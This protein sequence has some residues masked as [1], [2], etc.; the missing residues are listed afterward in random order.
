MTM[1][2]TYNGGTCARPGCPLTGCQAMDERDCRTCK[3]WAP[4]HRSDVWHCSSAIRCVEGG[5]HSKTGAVQEWMP[6]PPPPAMAP[7]GEP[8]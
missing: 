3:H 1:H 4:H 5:R 8:K 2:C 6:L 7:T